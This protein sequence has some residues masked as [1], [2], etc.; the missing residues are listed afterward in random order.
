MAFYDSFDEFCDDMKKLKG[1]DCYKVD[2]L[3]IASPIDKLSHY[4]YCKREGLECDFDLSF[5]HNERLQIQLEDAL[6][7]RKENELY[8]S[9]LNRSLHTF[10]DCFE[11]QNNKQNRWSLFLNN[12]VKDSELQNQLKEK[13]DVIADLQR[14]LKEKD[15]LITE[16][17]TKTTETE[18][19]WQEG[20]LERLMRGILNV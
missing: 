15:D 4:V 5:L 8:F 12:D 3:Q 2:N 18:E 19:D 6:K 10:E 17:Q 14:Q 11:V 13:D 7:L 16:L 20:S 9:Y 1:R